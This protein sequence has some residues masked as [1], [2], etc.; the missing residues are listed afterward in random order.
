[1]VTRAV[2]V[3]DGHAERVDGIPA[4]GGLGNRVIGGG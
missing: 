3:R 2:P 4:W 1:M